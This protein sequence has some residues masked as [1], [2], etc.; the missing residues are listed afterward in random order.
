MTTNQALEAALRAK[1]EFTFTACQMKDIR[2]QVKISKKFLVGVSRKAPT[3][4]VKTVS[5]TPLAD[6]LAM[7]AGSEKTLFYRT[8]REALRNEE[9]TARF[10]NA[11]TP[12]T[13]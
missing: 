1:Q 12:T 11:I 2:E 10:P 9:T 7:L 3:T 13:K 8:N 4:P 6:K 5:L